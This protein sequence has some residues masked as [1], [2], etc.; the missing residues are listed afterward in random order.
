MTDPF[1]DPFDDPLGLTRSAKGDLS[2][3]GDVII[4]GEF[5]MD[6][7]EYFLELLIVFFCNYK[8]IKYKLNN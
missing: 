8:K 6:E 2:A 7:S 4:W 3:F 5:V 1:D